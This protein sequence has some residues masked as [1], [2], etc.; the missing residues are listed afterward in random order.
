MTYIRWIFWTLYYAVSWRRDNSLEWA[1]NRAMRTRR[2]WWKFKPCVWHNEYG[3]WDVYLSEDDHYVSREVLD[4]EVFR[5]FE[6]KHIV[7]IRLYDSQ[8]KTQPPPREARPIPAPHPDD[9]YPQD[10]ALLSLI[11]A[12]QEH[13]C[14]ICGEEIEGSIGRPEGWC[15]S[16]GEQLYPVKIKL[17]FG[18]EFAHPDCVTQVTSDN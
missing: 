14:R 8:L 11:Q 16:F 5:D 18:R 2:P 6:T 9:E 17:A 15:Y 13:R 1:I 3:W 12:R 4:V 7:G 10:G